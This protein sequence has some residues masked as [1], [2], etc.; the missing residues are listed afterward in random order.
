MTSAAAQPGSSSQ[1][2]AAPVAG[3]G[4]ACRDQ[5]PRRH[6]NDRAGDEGGECGQRY[7]DQQPAQR[8]RE[9]PAAAQ[10]KLHG[11]HVA[12]DHGQQTGGLDRVA[13]ARQRG[14]PDGDRAL[15]DVEREDGG[16]HA[17]A[18]HPPGVAGAGAAGLRDAQVEP[19]GAPHEQVAGRDAADRVGDRDEQEGHGA[20]ATRSAGQPG[21]CPPR[22]GRQHATCLAPRRGDGQRPGGQLDHER[23]LSEGGVLPVRRRAGQPP[24]RGEPHAGG[25]CVGGAGRAARTPRPDQV[26]V[27]VVPDGDVRPHLVDQP[28]GGPRLRLGERPRPGVLEVARPAAGAPAG[29]EVAVEIHAPPVQ[30]GAV[31]EAVG[32]EVGDE[33][34]VDAGRQRHP[35]QHAHDPHAG[36]LRAVDA[37]DHQHALR[38]GRVAALVGDDRPAL[39][40]VAGDQHC[41]DGQRC[42]HA[43][44]TPGRGRR[45]RPARP[46]APLRGRSARWGVPDAP[47]GVGAFEAAGASASAAPSLRA[48]AA[49]NRCRPSSTPRPMG[50]ARAGGTCNGTPSGE[51]R[52]SCPPGGV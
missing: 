30:P 40:R 3:S 31:R 16:T 48:R 35:A 41:G 8:R 1:V 46:A 2:A 4:D 42:E 15:P 21:R 24:H 28:P 34:Q 18:G 43:G 49:S 29:R 22:R 51:C 27:L 33:P 26:H 11:E 39:R 20:Q 7:G 32:V 17:P 52:R 50:R 13:G 47:S 9:P 6:G 5:L 37:A 14:Q 44:T 38:A 25:A 36:A 23:A 19:G 10:A 12:G 45:V